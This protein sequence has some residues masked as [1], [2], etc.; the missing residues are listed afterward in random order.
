MRK[1]LTIKSNNYTWFYL[2]LSTISFDIKQKY[3]I[4]YNPWILKMQRTVNFWLN[5]GSKYHQQEGQEGQ[6]GSDGQ[7]GDNGQ[8]SQDGQDGQNDPI[9]PA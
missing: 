6:E 3:C 4:I 7:N 5:K 9:N 2:N 8:N 1:N